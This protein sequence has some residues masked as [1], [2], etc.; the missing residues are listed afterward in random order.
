MPRS[1]RQPLWIGGLVLALATALVSPVPAA[2]APRPTPTVSER[3]DRH[4]LA[5]LAFV[6]GEAIVRFRAGVGPAQRLGARQAAGADFERAL[7]L[8]RA[9]VVDVEGGV[10]GAVER[11]QGRPEVAFAQ[12]NYVYRAL[13]DLPN[14]P[15]FSQ[16]WGLGAIDVLAGWDATRGEGQTIAIVDTGVDLTH[17]DLAPRLWVNPSPG[18]AHDVH[19]YDF[20]DDDGDPDDYQYHG[21]H[22]A[23]TAAATVGNGV[24]VAGVA[25]AA[26]IMAV[27]VL[28]ANGSGTTAD[29]ADGVDYAAGKGA[30]V[31]NLSLG[32]SI[33]EDPDPALS[34]AVKRAGAQFDAVVVAAA[35]N[36]GE[37]GIGDDNDVE[38]QS[39]CQ[40]VDLV[41][42]P[43]LV[44][45]AATRADGQ[46]TD[47]SNWGAGSVHLAAPGDGIWSTRA[48]YQRVFPLGGAPEGFED[49]VAF[50]STWTN[51]LGTAAWER[52]S[53]IAS[54]GGEFSVADSPGGQY[55]P[56]ADTSLV[57]NPEFDASFVGRKGC[58]MHFDFRLRNGGD[59][60][61]VFAAGLLHSG[62]QLSYYEFDTDTS[63][64]G[65][66]PVQLP[67]SGLDGSAAVAPAF[68]FEADSDSTVGDGANV[69]EVELLCRSNVY[70]S[71]SYLAL[72]G[73]SM[74]APHVSGVAA[75]VR[76]AVPG[77]TAAQTVA[78]LVTGAKP[79]VPTQGRP[80]VT[81]GIVSAPG[82][83]AAAGWS[84]SPPSLP[85]AVSS[86]G[87][88]APVVASRLRKPNLG[89]SPRRLR[90]NRVRRIAYH[91]R[92]RPGLQGLT[93]LRTRV[94]A[95]TTRGRLRR[96]RHFTIARKRFAVPASGKVVTRIRLTPRQLRTLR[97]NKRLR[98]IVT[99]AVRDDEGRVARASKR[100]LL[101]PPRPRVR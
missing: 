40:S 2:G 6:P 29:V 53:G 12:P 78:A 88:P 51:F 22:V 83:L 74:A 76:A 54:D 46:L 63:G 42:P 99:V 66:R 35:G 16:L 52:D 37:D 81:N 59:G 79:L 32:S 45:V 38:P 73:T 28:D 94:Q 41:Q 26:R 96:L 91:F 14:D 30:K 39:P 80:T 3:L 61:D 10:R 34:Y 23:G 57:T 97:I 43:N 1:R 58:R 11:L 70:E 77:T 84:P 62:D 24:G 90:V 17:P 68:L 48:P 95:A 55:S 4:T 25:P 33:G 7:R 31:I 98:L 85:P 89:A 86:A 20:V 92:A 65:L 75:L 8:P 13:A 69:D 18:P 44:C 47:F 82:A 67:F 87:P 15:R 36:G 5:D 100:L 27:R 72:N 21:T 60:D 71:S 93:V 56:L 64:S 50:D 9:Q 49:A 19:G 101:L